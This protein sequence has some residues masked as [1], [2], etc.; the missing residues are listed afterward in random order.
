MVY[1]FFNGN[2]QHLSPHIIGN[3]LQYADKISNGIEEHFFYITFCSDK[4]LY[5]AKEIDEA[6]TDLFK[7]YNVTKY[8]YIFSK[9]ALMK[10][11]LNI[12]NQDLIIFHGC[13]SS[14]SW[15]LLMYLILLVFRMKKKMR[16]ISLVCWG[17]T[18][19]HY[20][21]KT[22]TAKVINY[23]FQSIF[24]N[25]RHIIT[26]SSGDKAKAS[27]L[28]PTASVTEIQYISQAKPVRVQKQ[29]KTIQ[30]MVSHSGWPHNNHFYS[31]D[32]LSKY[33]DYDMKIIC[34]LCYGDEKYIK[35]VI[36]KGKALYGD[37]FSYFTEL[38]SREEYS[39]LI[40]SIDVYVSAAEIQTGISALTR[41]L[42]CG[43][44]VY[45]TGN[46]L[47]SM[48]GYGFILFDIDDI[49][50]LKFEEFSKK[51]SDKEFKQNVFV[52]TEKYKNLHDLQIK[53]KLIFSE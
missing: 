31:F 5:K 18:D 28:Y 7:K 17:E 20:S 24:P 50:H 22:I 11:F 21:N 9:C 48:Q 41:T 53:W 27:K 49:K 30:I 4:M 16:R 14:Y 10:E 52:Y 29:D 2:I 47:H 43:G 8:K 45:A 15:Q 42:L 40:S 38:K 46:L 35:A 37:K 34:P 12:P 33:K 36:T 25:I 51:L 32:L 23:I 44:V 26:L 19:F 3:I 39:K 1:H 13:A 6:Y